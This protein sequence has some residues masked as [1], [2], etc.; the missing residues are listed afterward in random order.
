LRVRGS[1]APVA[2]G[3]SLSQAS[4]S[5]DLQVFR[6]SA[7]VHQKQGIVSSIG[8]SS[9]AVAMHSQAV[10]CRRASLIITVGDEVHHFVV[11]QGAC[12]LGIRAR[13]SRG[14]E[15]GGGY[16]CMRA[17]ACGGRWRERGGSRLS[18]QR[19]GVPV[20][21]RAGRDIPRGTSSHSRLSS[22]RCERVGCAHRALVCVL[23]RPGRRRHPGS[24]HRRRAT[25]WRRGARS[26]SGRRGAILT[27]LK[28]S[29]QDLGKALLRHP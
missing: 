24:G 15:R 28:H 6:S 2:L 3:Y 29:L 20:R 17:R 25:G 27:A 23:G 10:V 14:L 9:Q 7:L 4:G 12:E 18:R 21:S 11:A 8:T 22:A 5:P 16:R 1:R 26:S 19:R 13:A